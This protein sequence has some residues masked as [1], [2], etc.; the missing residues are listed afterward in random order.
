VSNAIKPEEIHAAVLQLLDLAY[1]AEL[2]RLDSKSTSTLKK[3]VK[4][5]LQHRKS[6]EAR[7]SR[8][9]IAFLVEEVVA[10]AY[11]EYELNP[12]MGADALER[13]LVALAKE[14][15]LVLKKE[16]LEELVIPLHEIERTALDTAFDAVGR[17]V[18]RSGRRVMAWSSSTKP[19]MTQALKKMLGEQG[20]SFQAKHPDRLKRSW[21]EV[22]NLL[23]YVVNAFRLEAKAEGRARAEARLA[24]AFKMLRRSW[25]NSAVAPPPA[26]PPAPIKT[27]KPRKK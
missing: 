15:H 18:H 3:A 4:P 21:L 20:I 6:I 10:P 19:K 2:G 22:S 1:D 24:E 14:H 8:S 25:T 16:A 13:R 7:K 23:L 9:K 11:R 5:L 17:V 27:K 12:E 26:A